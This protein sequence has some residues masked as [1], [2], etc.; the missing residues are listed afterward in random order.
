M[1]SPVKGLSRWLAP[2]LTIAAT[3]SLMACSADESMDSGS[4]YRPIT[5]SALPS[6]GSAVDT[7]YGDRIVSAGSCLAIARSSG[8][9]T[10]E[11]EVFSTGG[12][13]LG[14]WG[15]PGSG[16]NEVRAIDG[17]AATRDTILV[18][19]RG[20]TRLTYLDCAAQA[21]R[22]HELRFAGLSI[23]ATGR[24]TAV[25][26]LD[27][28][29]DSYG[30]W[31]VDGQIGD[32]I[33]PRVAPRLRAARDHATSIPN[34][35]L[36]VLDVSAGALVRY[37]RGEV[38]PEAIDTLP[39]SIQRP[40][41]EA[42]RQLWKGSSEIEAMPVAP[43]SPLWIQV[44]PGD[45]LAVGFPEYPSSNGVAIAL[46]HI[47]DSSFRAIAHPADSL[48][49]LG[50]YSSSGPVFS[51]DTLIGVTRDSVFRLLLNPR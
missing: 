42:F 3:L 28:V 10:P 37:R 4:A 23:V 6:F 46:W 45:T 8:T 15:T 26:T 19:D 20:N 24:E 14:R 11:V 39:E 38:A 18:W 32:S 30:I 9:D 17:M 36:A 41:R 40:L 47:G 1:S 35:G 12:A 5:L 43:L 50:V 34:G 29:A 51:G 13:R 22:S 16:P 27:P 7:S 21:V 44:L 2:T 49:A 31:I 33:G 25:L 48:L